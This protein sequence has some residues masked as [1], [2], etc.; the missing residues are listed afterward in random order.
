MK[1]GVFLLLLLCTARL[2]NAQQLSEYSETG[3]WA[4]NIPNSQAKSTAGI[5]SYVTSHVNGERNKVRAIY[6]WVTSNIR[7]DKDSATLINTDI[8]PD[9]R[10]TAALRRRRGV[11][12]N[13]A[14]IFNDICTKAGLTSFVIS[15]YTKQSGFVDRSGHSWCAVWVDKNWY[16]FD[17]TWDEGSSSNTKY[18]M[19][20]PAEFIES[21]MPFDPLWQFLDYPISHEQFYKGNF[22][23]ERGAAYFNFSDSVTAFIQ[24]DSLTR[25]Q[26]SAMRIEKQGLYNFRVKDNYNY[27][28][29]HIEMINQDKDV[30]LYNSSVADLNEVTTTL[31]NFIQ[32]RNKQFTPGKTDSELKA[33]LEGV[34][35]KLNTSLKKLN[36]VDKSQATLTLSTE[37]IR[38]RLEALLNKIKSQQD[39]LNHYLNTDKSARKSLFY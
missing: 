37:P 9:A 34:D 7:Y 28:K 15:G 32:Y 2:S 16:L 30:D 21:H 24:M 11:C 12:E 1:K 10:I 33:L 14:A 8:N 17:P 3:G 19:V 29:M 25:Y 13:F 39:F 4:I 36:E 35:T 6:A 22:S 23:K 31:N 20:S 38:T 18:F 26:S 5:A 27:V